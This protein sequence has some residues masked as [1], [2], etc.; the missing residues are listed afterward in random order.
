MH[1]S[2]SPCCFFLPCVHDALDGEDCRRH[3]KHEGK[4]SKRKTER[5]REKEGERYKEIMNDRMRG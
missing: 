4:D 2:E 3:G 5:G 1:I